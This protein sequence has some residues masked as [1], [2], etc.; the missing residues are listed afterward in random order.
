MSPRPIRKKVRDA[1]EL[2]ATGQADTIQEAADRVGMRREALSRAFNR[3][4]VQRLLH[5]RL[6]SF[7]TIH[8]KTRAQA[9][10]V[11]L[12]E[13]AKSED[14]R[15]RASQWIEQTTGVVAASAGTRGD[16]TAGL[17]GGTIVLNIAFKHVQ[18][19]QI[20]APHA[21]QTEAIAQIVEVPAQSEP[22]RILAKVAD[23][24][25]DDERTPGGRHG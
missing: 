17:G 11:F 6:N 20:G 21:H 18:T 9:A 10:V 13:R 7:R 5:D 14:I 4:D 23:E 1:V 22:A 19:G 16:P 3:E 8:A 25:A 12:S 15:L 24:P 2:Y